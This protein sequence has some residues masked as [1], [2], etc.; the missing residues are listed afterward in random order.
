MCNIYSK[1]TI[2]EKWHSQNLDFLSLINSSSCQFLRNSTYADIIEFQNFLLQLKNQRS[3][4]E[5]VC[6]FSII[7]ILKGKMTF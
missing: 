7:L 6:G 3:K 4:N 5:S 2:E 1:N